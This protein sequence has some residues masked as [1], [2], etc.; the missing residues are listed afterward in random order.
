MSIRGR[1]AVLNVHL[2][3]SFRELNG[4]AA[5]GE[6]GTGGFSDEF[7][8]SSPLTA[9]HDP[10]DKKICLQNETCIPAY[11]PAEIE[12]SWQFLSDHV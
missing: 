5:N 6:R 1:D 12:Q 8:A 7:C 4:S 3:F 2:L 10:T 11:V 9:H